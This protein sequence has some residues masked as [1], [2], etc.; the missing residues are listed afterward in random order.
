M[1]VATKIIGKVLIRRMSDSVDVKLRKEQAGFRQ[2][3]ADIHPWQHR[4][5]SSRM[6]FQLVRMF[7]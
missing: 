5:G 7:R 6:E 4:E 3:R 1:S 2:Y